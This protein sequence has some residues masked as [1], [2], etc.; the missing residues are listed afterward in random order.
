MLHVGPGLGRSAAAATSRRA[1]ELKA[2][3]AG[4][5]PQ[6]FL[7]LRRDLP[8]ATAAPRENVP[9]VEL[10][11]A[12]RHLARPLATGTLGHLLELGAEL[13]VQR[14]LFL[15]AQHI[16]RLLD[17]LK[18]LLGC[19]VVGVQIGVIFPRQLA[20]RLLDLIGGS[21]PA[22]AENL[23]VVLAHRRDSSKVQGVGSRESGVEESGVGSSTQY[24]VL[25]TRPQP[26]ALAL[27]LAPQP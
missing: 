26:P 15:V 12:R 20:I 24:S 5:L 18:L 16:V 21:P 7:Q 23:V 14:P 17:F 19:L 4:E 3:A 13:V 22:D 1:P 8:A 10:F 25:S 9:E 6:Q 27:A 2:P 11:K